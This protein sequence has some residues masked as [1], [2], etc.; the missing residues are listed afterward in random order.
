MAAG[1]DPDRIVLGSG[2]PAAAVALPARDRGGPRALGRMLMRSM[3]D[4]WNDTPSA[5]QMAGLGVFDR[6]SSETGWSALLGAPRSCGGRLALRRARSRGRPVRSS[7]PA[8]IDVGSAETFR[9]EDVTCASRVWQAGG[10]AEPHV[11]PGGFHGFD[12]PVPEAALSV[13]AR[14]ARIRCCAGCWASEPPPR[15]GRAIGEER[16]WF[17]AA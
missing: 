10:S 16:R 14:A 12:S 1:G 11:W 15:P 6:T 4:D 13:D 3:L 5:H 8:F 17:G 9:D 7:P 2:G